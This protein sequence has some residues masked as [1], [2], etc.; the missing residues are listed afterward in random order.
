MK[1]FVARRLMQGALT[2]WVVSVV[3]FALMSLVPG[4]YFD[5]AR[6][7]PRLSPQTVE[8][9]RNR[10]GELRTLPQRYGEWLVSCFAGEGGYSVV[11]QVPV[12][13]LMLPRLVK[14]AQLATAGL[15]LSWLTALVL[16]AWSANRAGKHAAAV[17][18]W[19]TSALAAIPELVLACGLMLIGL[20]AGLVRE[21]NLTIPALALG[22][23]G[24]PAL[25]PQVRAGL[26]Q[27]ADA[28]YLE[29]AWAHGIRGWRFSLLFWLRA[30]ANPLLPLL[31]LSV[32]TMLS[33]SL[34]VEI[35]CG[36]PGLGPLF[37]SS[38]ETRDSHVALAVVLIASGLL[39]TANTVTDILQ[40]AADPR[41]RESS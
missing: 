8:A 16:G 7:D 13:H 37:L 39:I 18:D 4:S 6:L 9:M 26:R 21:D 34:V 10:S 27:V 12:L 25:L 28:P 2:L 38:V 31:G 5:E 20:Y 29:L 1:R 40:A 22:M 14:T 19:L 15:A 30:A 35:I 32:G 17:A 24:I 23:G 36:W 11:Y 41:I 3:G 33:S